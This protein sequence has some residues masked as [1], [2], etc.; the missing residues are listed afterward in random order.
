MQLLDRYVLRNF[1]EPL[2]LCFAA[3]LGIWWIFDF[4]GP[5]ADLVRNGA[6][7][8][9]LGFYYLCQLPQIL[10]ITLPISLLLAVLFCFSRMSRSNEVIAIL[11]SGR[12]LPRL[13]RPI[14]GVALL[15]CGACLSLTYE[16]APLSEVAKQRLL[17]E[18]K[19]THRPNPISG[20]LRGHL[21]RDRLSNRTW[22]IEK[23]LVGSPVLEGVLIFEQ[24][25]AGDVFRKLFAKTATHD[26]V[27]GDWTF[28]KGLS[29]VVS[30]EGLVQSVQRFDEDGQILVERDWRETPKRI[31]ASNLDPQQLTVPE[32]SELIAD[33]ADFPRRHLAK[34]ETVLQDRWAFPWSCFIVVCF[35]APLS[36]VTSRRGA[37]QGMG[38]AILLVFLMLIS[39]HFFQALG[40][41]AWISPTAAAW[42][43]QAFFLILGLLL[44]WMRSANRDLAS[45][46]SKK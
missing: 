4:S 15:G 27:T 39:R 6:S 20:Q 13:L 23:M 25:E 38:L 12:S 37:V 36:I 45:F 22:F 42:G 33:N 41:G 34:Y 31:I 8:S 28:L 9:Q 5:G 10:L 7:L 21:F 2:L 30:K 40:K 17:D 32:L 24:N 26:P 1:L 29:V 44:L 35:A 46:F 14:L 11:S 3:F 16:Y 18:I 19:S 43:P